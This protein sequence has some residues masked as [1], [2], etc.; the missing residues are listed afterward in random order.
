MTG[1][2]QLGFWIFRAPYPIWAGP[3]IGDFKGISSNSGRFWWLGESGRL[4]Q[5]STFLKNF[6]IIIFHGNNR[7]EGV[8]ARNSVDDRG[9]PTRILDFSG[10]P[11]RKPY[12]IPMGRLGGS[13]GFRWFWRVRRRYITPV[14]VLSIPNDLYDHFHPFWTLRTLCRTLWGAK[15]HPVALCPGRS[16]VLSRS[17]SVKNHAEGAKIFAK[18]DDFFSTLVYIIL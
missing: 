13:G 15:T 11:S 2:Y 7:L 4:S 1:G 16:L 14:I 18:Q 6:F 12:V 17:L 3:Q 5:R 9:V 8:R 10:P